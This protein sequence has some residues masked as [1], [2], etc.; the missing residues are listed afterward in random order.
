MLK[1]LI[2]KN[3]SEFNYLNLII[4]QVTIWMKMTRNKY[5][6]STKKSNVNK[7]K[8]ILSF[9]KKKFL[10]CSHQDKARKT[11]KS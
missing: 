8:I 11:P 10:D 1:A 4:Q 6:R 3:Y 2:I 9:G 7:K 5:F